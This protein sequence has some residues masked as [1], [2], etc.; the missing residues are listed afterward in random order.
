VSAGRSKR[1]SMKR[2]TDVWSYTVCDTKARFE[3][4]EIAT[5][6]TRMP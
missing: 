2:R 5:N 4:G 3:Y 6:G 1:V